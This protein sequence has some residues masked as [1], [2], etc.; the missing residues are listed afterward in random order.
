M[1]AA[2]VFPHLP[3][4][5]HLRLVGVMRSEREGISQLRELAN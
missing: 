3:P 4:S 2:N 5:T 1:V